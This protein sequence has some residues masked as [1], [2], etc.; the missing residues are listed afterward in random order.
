MPSFAHDLERLI[1]RAQSDNDAIERAKAALSQ[2]LA[3]MHD[4]AKLIDQADDWRVALY[5]RIAATIPNAPPAPDYPRTPPVLNPDDEERLWRL[6]QSLTQP[7][8]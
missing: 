4:L 7:R 1:D 3:G 8:A 6:A 2:F 5:H